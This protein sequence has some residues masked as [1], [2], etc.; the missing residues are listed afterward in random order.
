MYYLLLIPSVVALLFT[1]KSVLVGGY[2]ESYKVGNSVVPGVISIAANMETMPFYLYISTLPPKREAKVPIIV[3]FIYNVMTILTGR[4]FQMVSSMM[5]I[6]I[7]AFMRNTHGETWVTKKHITMGC[8]AAPFLLVLLGMYDSIRAG[9]R[10]ES[11]S[12]IASL[13][14]FFDQIGGSVN[15]IK[16]EK[17][18]EHR[19]PNI[20]F[21]SFTGI[22]NLLFENKIIAPLLHIKVFEGN[23]VAHALYGHSMSHTLSLYDYKGQYLQ[24]H[25]VGS[26]YIAELYH[27]FGYLGVIIGNIVY[28]YLLKLINLM[29]FNKPY[30]CALLFS[31]LHALLLAP[32]GG[33]D[34]FIN[35]AFGIKVMAVFLFIMFWEKN[36]KS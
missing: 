32:R 18:Y 7:Y 26:C 24:G 27:D 4:R 35:E 11:T 17:Y 25:G 33:F 9:K 31:M 34:M 12:F 13:L 2:A 5:I 14:D 16:R 21:Y 20:R 19:L 28:G 36:I 30:I 23:S 3:F 29:P 1:I 10:V 6:I 8:V 22:Y 15:V